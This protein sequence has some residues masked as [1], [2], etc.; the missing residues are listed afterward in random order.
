M[1]NDKIEFKTPGNTLWRVIRLVF[2]KKIPFYVIY[3]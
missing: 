1:S 3:N 2:E